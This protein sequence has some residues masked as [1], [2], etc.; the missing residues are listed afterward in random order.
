M[1][2][3]E[4]DFF[5]ICVVAAIVVALTPTVLEKILGMNFATVMK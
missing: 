2:R 1:K 5:V 3:G 4:W